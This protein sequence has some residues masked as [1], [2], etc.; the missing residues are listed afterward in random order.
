MQEEKKN[1]ITERDRRNDSYGHVLKYTSIFGGVQG[2]RILVDVVRNKLAALL[3]HSTGLGLNAQYMNSAE[4]ANSFT[5]FG[6]GFSAVQQLSELF[7]EGDIEKTRRF[8]GVIRTW[9]LLAALCGVLLTLLLSLLAHSWFY[10][11]GDPS[12]TDIMLLCLFV[13]TLPLEEGECSILKGMR[14]LHQMA[15]VEAT[16]AICTLLLT[17]PV[18]YMLGVRGIVLALALVSS[19]KVL[20][21]MVVTCRLFAYRVHPFSRQVIGA[22]VQMIVRGIP[23]MLTAVFGSLTTTALFQYCLNGSDSDIGLYKSAYS[24]M[25]TYTGIVFIA[26]GN[27]FFPRLSSVNHNRARMNYAINQQV[28]VSVLLITPLLVAFVLAMPWVMRLLYSSEFLP[29]V[30]MAQCAV[31]YMFFGAITKPMAYSS[32]AKGDSLMYLFV[33]ALYNG[34]FIGLMF[35]GYHRYGLMGAGIALSLAALFDMLLIGTVYGFRYGIRL[36]AETIRLATF[37]GILLMLVVLAC[38]PGITWLKYAVGI[39]VFAISLTFSYR[40][41]SQDVHVTNLFRTKWNKLKP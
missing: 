23:F 20:I 10:P 4:V 15:G 1:T 32:L 34:V 36:R 19:A 39:S 26:L 37:Q 2:L 33:E 27:D 29:A 16:I 21:H 28:D 35:Y 6:I 12:W 5:N 25:V 24:L 7:E 8:V 22:G 18:Y 30:T 13:A 40:Q 9:S 41:L 3:L 31:F 17:I 14:K 38:M 11:D